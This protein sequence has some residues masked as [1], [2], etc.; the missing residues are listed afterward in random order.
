[1]EKKIP[2]A[3]ANRSFS[4]LLREVQNGASFTVTSHGR[5][6]ARLVPADSETADRAA[7]EAA[8]DALLARLR[9]QPA[10]NL[11][12]WTREELYE[13]KPWRDGPE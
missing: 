10:L 7:R 2:A 9:S 5:P 13:R 3:E 4:R 6:V 11:G 8:F 1:M 12:K